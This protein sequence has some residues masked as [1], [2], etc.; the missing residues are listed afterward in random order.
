MAYYAGQ[1]QQQYTPYGVQAPVPDPYGYAPSPGPAAAYPPYGTQYGAQFGPPVA[2]AATPPPSYYPSGYSPA[3]VSCTNEPPPQAVTVT[4]IETSPMLGDSCHH[5]HVPVHDHEYA[6]R[7]VCVMV[8]SL[9]VWMGIIATG[10]VLMTTQNAPVWWIILWSGFG[11]L[12]LASVIIM[13]W[14]RAR[15]LNAI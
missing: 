9:F 6:R 11:V 15:Y 5:H 4:V 14:R 7:S 3:D 2:Q 1:Q 12:S 10:V 13:R 8:F